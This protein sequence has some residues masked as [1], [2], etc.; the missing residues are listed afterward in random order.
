[1]ST[2]IDIIARRTIDIV[3]DAGEP[4]GQAFVHLGRP[5]QEP[6]GEWSIP[7]QIVGLGDDSVYRLLGLDAIQALQLVHKVI[8]GILAG[9]R[10]GEA[11]RLRWEGASELGFPVPPQSIP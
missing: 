2:M 4:V 1:M 9:T 8:G 5:S 10:E 6:T 11:H 3:D 7:Y